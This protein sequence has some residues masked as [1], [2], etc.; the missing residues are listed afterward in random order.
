MMPSP[1][2]FLHRDS[3]LTVKAQRQVLISRA[4]LVFDVGIDIGQRGGYERQICEST[5]TP[6]LFSGETTHGDQVNSTTIWVIC[7]MVRSARFTSLVALDASSTE[8]LI[9]AAIP[10]VRAPFCNSDDG[11]N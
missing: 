8:Y 1:S 4:T 2:L 10:T 11:T 7:G 5:N 9:A 6:K 3:L